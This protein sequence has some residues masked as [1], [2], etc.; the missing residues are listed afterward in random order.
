ML[1]SEELVVVVFGAVPLCLVI[2]ERSCNHVKPL[3]AIGV[4]KGSTSF[5]VRCRYN[6]YSVE[7]NQFS[8]TH[9]SIATRFLLSHPTHFKVP[10]S[11]F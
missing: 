5:F 10:F 2:Q 4:L 6:F 11:S 1:F 9:N 7:C 3:S 8:K